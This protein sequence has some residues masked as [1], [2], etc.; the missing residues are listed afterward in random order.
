MI[1]KGV[2]RNIRPAHIDA[3]AAVT[4]YKNGL[5]SRAGLRIGKDVAGN[6]ITEVVSPCTNADRRRNVPLSRIASDGVHIALESAATAPRVVV[7]SCETESRYNFGKVRLKSV[8]RDQGSIPGSLSD[9]GVKISYPTHTATEVSLE[10]VIESMKKAAYSGLIYPDTPLRAEVRIPPYYGSLF[11]RPHKDRGVVEK[12]PKRGSGRVLAGIGPS[13]GRS[14]Y[15][16]GGGGSSYGGGLPWG[17][18]SGYSPRE[19]DSYPDRRSRS[20]DAGQ[21]QVSSFLPYIN[22]SLEALRRAISRYSSVKNGSFQELLTNYMELMDIDHDND[23][24]VIKLRNKMEKASNKKK[25]MKTRD[26]ILSKRSA[27][28]AAE[29][30]RLRDGKIMHPR[31]ETVIA[32]CIGLQLDPDSSVLF[33]SA[34]GYR[35]E[36]YEKES[37]YKVVLT[38]AFCLD[39]DQANT[40]LKHSGMM[41]LNEGY[42]QPKKS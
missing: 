22:V 26:E 7:E 27:I 14:L 1:A 18:D 15:K 10:S 34:A 6:I 37:A 24:E 11:S 32:L 16:S 13:G 40:I 31:K 42:G 33:Y 2:Y 29:I 20:T 25:Y 3:V 30:E 36:S 9:Y 39:I 38:T 21:S 5:R 28:S 23:P 8:L 41:E 19:N 12:A 35:I 4:R 17:G